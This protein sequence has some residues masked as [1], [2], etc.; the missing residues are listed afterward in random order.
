MNHSET[1]FDIRLTGN[2]LSFSG[3]LEKSDY[4]KIDAFLKKVDQT[5][6]ADTCKINLK[7]LAFL[8]SSG[9]RSIATFI[10]GSSKRFEIQI[11]NDITWQSESI[12]T[13][14]YLKPDRIE[15]MS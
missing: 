13:L 11:N 15:I 14:A 3:N 8:N 12:P 9:I 7:K 6:N 4:S 10:L 5:L 2:T 1:G